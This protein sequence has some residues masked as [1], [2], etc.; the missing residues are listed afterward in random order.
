MSVHA[1][2]LKLNNILLERFKKDVAQVR[3]PL[4]W[5]ILSEGKAENL[6]RGPG[7]LGSTE[8]GSAR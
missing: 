4:F 3:N 5:G 8:Q 7:F 2:T 1:K 6:R